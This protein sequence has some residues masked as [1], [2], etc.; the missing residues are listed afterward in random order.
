MARPLAAALALAGAL[1]AGCAGGLS[2]SGS[3]P[4]TDDGVQTVSDAAAAAAHRT[5]PTQSSAVAI[6]IA[7]A[8][9]SRVRENADHIETIDEA[10]STPRAQAC[11]GRRAFYAPDRAGD[12]NSTE[13]VFFYDAACAHVARDVVRVYAPGGNGSQ[14]VRRTVS[15]RSPQSG[16]PVAVRTETATIDH[17]V[18]GRFGFP[19]AGEGFT[20]TEWSTLDEGGT[21]SVRSASEMVVLPGRSGI[22]AFCQD[23]AGYSMSG[24]PSL[25]ATFGWQGGSTGTGT[26]ERR[27]AFVRLI[28]TQRGTS[29]GGP[30]GA[31]S[32][33]TGARNTICPIGVP[34]FALAGGTA[35]GQYVMPVRALFR[36]GRVWEFTVAGATFSNGYRLDVKTQHPGPAASIAGKIS[37]GGTPVATFSLDAFGNGA[38]TVTSTGA[39]YRMVDWVVVR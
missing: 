27:G 12:A 32:I 36:D 19:R 6:A 10:L 7:D 26:I 23:S 14:T 34:A 39:E 2:G 11:E 22:S 29:Y 1:T 37:A 20:R 38:L 24:V 8:F 25:D 33:S 3:M 16:A 30:I 15:I 9:G 17:A 13:S 31:L 18:F 4:F 35:R 28:S 5:T 21:K